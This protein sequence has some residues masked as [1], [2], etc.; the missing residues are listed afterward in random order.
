MLNPVILAK[1]GGLTYQPSNTLRGNFGSLNYAGLRKSI[2]SGSVSRTLADNSIQSKGATGTTNSTHRE[3]LLNP[4]TG[5]ILPTPTAGYIQGFFNRTSSS[6]AHTL[7]FLLGVTNETP[8]GFTGWEIGLNGFYGGSGYNF[9]YM[10]RFISGSYKGETAL[11]NSGA[12]PGTWFRVRVDGDRVR[13]YVSPTDTD[14][15]TRSP[16]IDTTLPYTGSLI[17]GLGMKFNHPSG[18]SESFISNVTIA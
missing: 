12:N 1:L 4:R 16:I 10:G 15:N 9:A 18:G 2:A 8:S 11:T 3:F 7:N 14:L 13:V 5:I 17:G 6:G